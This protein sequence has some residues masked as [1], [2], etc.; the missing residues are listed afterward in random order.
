[1]S[2]EEITRVKKLALVLI[3]ST[4]VIVDKKEAIENAEDGKNLETTAGVSKNGENPKSSLA[5]VPYI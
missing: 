4:P 1:M 3:T 5:Q 2:L